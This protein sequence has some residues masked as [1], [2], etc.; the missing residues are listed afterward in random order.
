[1][2]GAFLS[3]RGARRPFAGFH[4]GRPRFVLARKASWLLRAV[5]DT[6]QN[7]ILDT[8]RITSGRALGPG[9]RPPLADALLRSTFLAV[10][11]SLTM[12]ALFVWQ[13]YVAGQDALHVTTL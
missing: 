9:T 3:Q 8:L 6:L 1:M 10:V 11:R 7:S 12:I 5:P 2:V 13:C 4:N